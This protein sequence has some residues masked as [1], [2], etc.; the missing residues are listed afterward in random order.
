MKQFDKNNLEL[1]FASTK[2]VLVTIFWGIGFPCMKLVSEELT[3]FSQIGCRFLVATIVLMIMFYKKIHLLNMSALKNGALLS[4]FLFLTYVL[5]T[6]GIELTTSSR[7]SFFCCLAVII[8]PIYN[9]IFFKA[10]LVAKNII[11]IIVCVLGIF[12]LSYSK[13]IA[14][15]LNSGDILC[16]MCSCC[17]AGHIVLT[18]KIAKNNDP[19]VVTLI[20]MA[21][22]SVFA[23]VLSFFSTDEVIP[24][25]V[26]LKTILSLLFI[27]IFGTGVAFYWQTLCQKSVSSIRVGIIFSLEPVNGAL[28]SWIF[29]GDALGIQHMIGGTLIF[30]SL[31]VSEIKC[32]ENRHVKRKC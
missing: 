28:A 20:Q 9:V 31:I 25:I 19:A 29:I 30:I 26:S 16:L 17:S 13:G 12:M 8:I 18:E 4:I 6:K 32:G 22:I 2:L 1:S 5:A 24:T 14:L 15:N 11:S 21:F 3:T 10:K 27:G 23:F 7:A